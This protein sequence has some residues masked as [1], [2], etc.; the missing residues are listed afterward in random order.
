[1]RPEALLPW[2]GT[3]GMGSRVFAQPTSEVGRSFRPTADSS[4]FDRLSAHNETLLF[5]SVP[6]FSDVPAQSLV[7]SG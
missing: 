4:L 2:S 5:S 3:C 1:M 6:L 7:K